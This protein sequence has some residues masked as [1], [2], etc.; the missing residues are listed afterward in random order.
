MLKEGLLILL[1][2]VTLTHGQSNLA[3]EVANLNGSLISKFPNGT[4]ESPIIQAALICSLECN[5]YTIQVN[6]QGNYR[7]NP[8]IATLTIQLNANG[9]TVNDALN[10][11]TNKVSAVIATLS[12]NGLKSSDWKTTYLNIYPNTSYV[13]GSIVTYGQIA[14]LDMTITIPIVKSDGTIIANIYDGLA[15]V[16]NINIYSLTFDLKDKATAF[17]QARKLA[18]QNAKQRAGDYAKA[19]GVSLGSPTTVSDSFYYYPYNY[20]SNSPGGP[21]SRTM[22]TVSVGQVLITYNIVV[23]FETR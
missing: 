13:N 6:G 19:A 23:T 15:K 3:K 21:G 7:V 11:L 18:Y 4:K 22:T 20:P 14:Y 1:L 16:E 10:A 17:V 12:A 8:D 9:L 5:W 2:T